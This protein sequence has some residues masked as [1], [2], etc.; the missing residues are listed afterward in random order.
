M[1][2]Y[3]TACVKGNPDRWPA[4]EVEE[5]R[6]CDEMGNLKLTESQMEDIIAFI[7]TLTDGY[8]PELQTT[9]TQK[10]SSSTH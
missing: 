5:G 1:R 3:N 4:A 6:N 9:S 2:F 10:S 7:K 8:K